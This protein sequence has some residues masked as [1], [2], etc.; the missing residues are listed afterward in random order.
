M[1]GGMKSDDKKPN[2]YLSNK[3]FLKALVEH[4][5]TVEAWDGQGESPRVNDFIGQCIYL[6]CTRMARR[7]N[8]NGYSYIDDMCGDAI[9][10]CVSAV[11]NFDPRK[12]KNPFGYFSCI[13]WRAFIR[14]IDAE[15]EQTYVKIKNFENLHVLDETGEF[16]DRTGRPD[17]DGP[18][19]V[20]QLGNEHTDAFVRNFER[21]ANRRRAKKPAGVPRAG[22]SRDK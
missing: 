2:H 10:N 12:S 11:R 4:K 17:T 6:I 21:R 7:A 13:A 3:D 5:R 8:F 22:R 19:R 15:Q 1:S 18:G 20:R 9:E 16:R 14:R